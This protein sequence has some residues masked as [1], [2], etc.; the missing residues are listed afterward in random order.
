VVSADAAEAN[1]TD[2]AKADNTVFQ[3][4]MRR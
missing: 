4:R 1:K 2:A 3:A